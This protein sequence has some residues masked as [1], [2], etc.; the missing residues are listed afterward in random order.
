MPIIAGGVGSGLDING[1]VSQLVEAE[2][3]PV[4][5]RL[6]A[7]EIDLGSELSAFGTL[8]SAL[9]AFQ[10]SVGKLED[11][12]AFQVF[13]ANSSNEDVFTASA[14]KTAVAGSYDIEVI[15]LATAEKLATKDYSAATDIVG[16]GTLDISLGSDTFQLTIDSSNS[17]LEGIRDAI[18]S[19]S[20]NP[21]VTA[22]LISVDSGTQMILSSNKVGSSNTIGVVAND[23]DGS[24]GYNLRDIRTSKLDTLQDAQDAIIEVDSQEVTRDSNSFSDVITGVSFNL[25]SDDIGTVEKLTIASDTQA[26]KKDIEGFVNNYN[27]LVGV[28]KGLSNF[29]Q[30]T[31]VAGPLNGD[32]VVRGIQNTLRQALSTTVT[33]GVFSNL[34]ELG[35]S[36]G[37]NGN[38]DINETVL[39]EQLSSNLNDVNTFFSSATGMAQTFSTAL[40]GYTDN[41]G[42]IDSRT[43]GLQNRLDGLDDKR[44]ALTRRMSSYEARLTAQFTAMDIL[45]SQ[46]QSTGSFLTQ[47]LENL[48]SIN[49]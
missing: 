19:A 21:G 31:L 46:L 30:S 32:S 49:S 9:S 6:N 41:D 33:G 44:D 18:N 42:I 40:S 2:A 1:L 17:T 27:T 28:M 36:F 15:Q 26:I 3:E 10:T 43:D 35:I 8:K 23:D 14:D 24:D 13:T 11:E 38:L 39:D 48:P 20:D 22:T 4:N 29:D 37:E 16:T 47:Q 12:T 5:T 25:V 7:Q 45:V 34:S